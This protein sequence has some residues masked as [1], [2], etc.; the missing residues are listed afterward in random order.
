MINWAQLGSLPNKT[1]TH[2]YIYHKH[3]FIAQCALIMLTMA[4]TCQQW[5]VVF[6]L[7]TSSKVSCDPNVRDSYVK[8][9]KSCGLEDFSEQTVTESGFDCKTACLA[10]RESGGCEAYKWNTSTG[11][12]LMQQTLN[13]SMSTAPEDTVS[14]M[15]SVDFHHT[16]CTDEKACPPNYMCSDP[17]CSGIISN[18]QPFSDCAEV[19][20]EYPTS[21]SGVYRIIPAGTQQIKHVWCDM[22]TDGGGWTVFLKR[23]DGSVDF[24][25]DLATYAAGFGDVNGEYWLGLDALHAM[26]TAKTY[27]LRA[28]VSDWAGASTYSL[29][30]SMV[31]ADAAA[32]YRLTLGAFLSGDGGSCLTN[33]NQNQ[34]F[35]TKDADR[36]ASSSIHCATRHHG[37]FW[38]KSCS[39]CHITAK[40]YIGGA[41]TSNYNDG[42]QWRTWS[43]HADSWYSMKMVDMKIRP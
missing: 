28:D 26:T 12:C 33:Q 22:D 4:Q 43:K 2:C 30:A 8:K 1:N 36:D 31:V 6:V 37:G 41:Y 17:L 3:N 39:E 19:L 20:S 25:Q 35:S 23:N 29:H 7:L 42:I 15:L 34:R 27:Q 32:G 21:P 9:I 13:V 16:P 11:A 18:C 14:V 38:Y 10:L 24:Y 40:Y 5:I